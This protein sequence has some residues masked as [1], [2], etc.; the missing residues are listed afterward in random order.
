[1]SF[2]I[3]VHNVRQQSF[4]DDL[5]YRYYQIEAGVLKVSFL[6]NEV[7][8]ALFVDKFRAGITSEQITHILLQGTPFQL[9]VW[10][11]LSKIP[12]GSTTTYQD[13]ACAIGRPRAW[14]AVANAVANNKIA[15]FIPCHRVIRKNGQ[16]GGYKWGIARKASLLASE[17]PIK[18]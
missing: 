6:N 7:C 1:M 8:Q 4:V 16:L 13:L 11:A 2:F 12:W 5:P 17:S 10:L 18:S 14:R 9:E 15:Y 3:N